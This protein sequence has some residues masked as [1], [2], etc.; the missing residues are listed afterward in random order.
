MRSLARALNSMGLTLAQ[1]GPVLYFFLA[2]ARPFRLF[3]YVGQGRGEGSDDEVY[4]GYNAS[5]YTSRLDKCNAYTI[6][7]DLFPFCTRDTGR[8]SRASMPVSYC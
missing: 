7:N 5:L 4:L 6:H 8:W 3:I 2:N 1:R